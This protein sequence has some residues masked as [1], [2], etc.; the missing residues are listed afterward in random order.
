MLFDMHDLWCDP[1]EVETTSDPCKGLEA[2]RKGRFDLLLLDL[3]M[4]ALNGIELLRTLRTENRKIP[5]LVISGNPMK[6]L[7]Q[8]GGP[9]NEEQRL[10]DTTSGIIGKPFDVPAL[11]AQIQRI[12]S[13]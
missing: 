6:H 12:F 3:K 8:G 10:L 4:P 13:Q 1:K 5:V 11:L 7:G 9:D 2:A